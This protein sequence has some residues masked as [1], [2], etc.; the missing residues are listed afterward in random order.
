[1]RVEMRPIMYTPDTGAALKQ[2][3]AAFESVLV[4]ACARREG[5]SL[6]GLL[7]IQFSVAHLFMTRPASG[8]GSYS[9]DIQTFFASADLEHE[10]WIGADWAARVDAVGRGAQRALAT[11]HKTRLTAAE[12]DI[13]SAL[14]DDS[15]RIVAADA[16]AHLEALGPIL[17]WKDREGRIETVSFDVSPGES[18]GDDHVVLLQPAEMKAFLAITPQK[19][20][21]VGGFKLYRRDGEVLRFREAW[22]HD[23]QVHEHGG[24]CGIRGDLVLHPA[25][26]PAEQLLIIKRLSAAARKE[27]FKTIARSRLVGLT[28]SKAITENGGTD[29]LAR[30][31]LLEDY[32]NNLTGWLGLGHCDGG[33]TGSG[34]MEA[35]C[36]VVDGKLAVDCI[37][38]ELAKS[39]FGDFTVSIAAQ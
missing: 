6:I 17:V 35:F 31:H 13:L 25:A 12:R 22:V 15:A 23:G 20:P 37:G 30:R 9:R 27:G 38:K 24:V 10:A 18:A 16:P 36:L 34:S 7:C 26:T 5:F 8:R 33:S 32:L 11:V 2:T 14:I 3:V 21:H 28:V 1:M 39:E 4:Q 19:E 29:D